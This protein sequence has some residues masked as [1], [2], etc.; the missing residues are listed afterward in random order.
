MH[1]LNSKVASGTRAGCRARRG[2]RT[3]RQKPNSVGVW[4]CFLPEI[5]EKTLQSS[6]SASSCK[7]LG[8]CEG[9]GSGHQDW[10]FLS[11]PAEGRLRTSRRHSTGQG[12][13]EE[14][15]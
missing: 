14:N 4:Y 10:L 11:W 5:T 1:H 9:G 7:C 8:S 13:V 6:R 15:P 2:G 12:H 3:F